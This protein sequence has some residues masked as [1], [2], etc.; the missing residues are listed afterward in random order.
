MNV[1]FSAALHKKQIEQEMNNI[2]NMYVY[3]K[4]YK[5]YQHKTKSSAKS[6]WDFYNFITCTVFAMFFGAI[7]FI[8]SVLQWK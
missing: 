4:W 6:E 7:I 1:S 5:K 2:K 3:K 8:Y